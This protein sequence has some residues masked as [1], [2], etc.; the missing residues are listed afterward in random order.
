MIRVV[1][2]GGGLR[3]IWRRLPGKGALLPSRKAGLLEWIGRIAQ[4]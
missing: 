2:T 1:A 3:L 4:W